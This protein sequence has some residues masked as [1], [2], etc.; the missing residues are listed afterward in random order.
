M[1]VGQIVELPIQRKEEH[2][3]QLAETRRREAQ[4]NRHTETECDNSLPPTSDVSDS[5][6]VVKH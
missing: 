4:D 3:R 6:E 2:E 5:V 1:V